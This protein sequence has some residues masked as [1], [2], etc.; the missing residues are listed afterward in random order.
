MLK[1]EKHANEK[2]GKQLPS[3]CNKHLVL[4]SFSVGFGEVYGKQGLSKLRVNFTVTAKV[5]LLLPTIDVILN[6]PEV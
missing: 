6:Q 4:Q 5:V 2:P 3:Y 1:N